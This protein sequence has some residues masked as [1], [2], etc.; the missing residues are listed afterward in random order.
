MSECDTT[1]IQVRR[2][3]Y[4]E[5]ADAIRQRIV[6][7]EFGPGEVLPSEARFGASYEASRVTI[8]KALEIL[9]TDG[10]VDARQG[11][12]WFVASDPVPQPLTGLATIEAQLAESGR[13]SERRILDFGLV[14]A[15]RHV[16]ALLGPRVLVT[17][18]LN[19]ADG[20]PFARVTVWCRADL[21][22]GLTRADVERSTFSSLLPGA[23]G[24]ARQ[25]IGAAL[26]ADADADLL[27]IP[28]QSP[29]LVVERTTFDLDGEVVL[30][31]EHV[32]PGH[33]TEFVV[34]LAARTDRG[35]T[36][37]GLRLLSEAGIDRVP[38]VDEPG[39]TES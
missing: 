10:L 35:D 12:G 36:P 4:Q 25:T 2:I 17:R 1:L 39:G 34:E 11:F 29:V 3:R 8:R 15:P 19:L 32:F 37:P 7:G 33:R 31:S 14:D 26:V 28:R 38:T 22:A 16:V 21:G 9:R 6:A 18:R 5:I 30:V 27:G 13:R 20:Q 24:R 23:L